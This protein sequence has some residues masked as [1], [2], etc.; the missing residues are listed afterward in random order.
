MNN[1]YIIRLH[2]FEGKFRLKEHRCAFTGET[3]EAD[4]GGTYRQAETAFGE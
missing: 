2:F 3:V 4:T 1:K